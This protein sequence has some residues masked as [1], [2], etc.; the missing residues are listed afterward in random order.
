M[1]TMVVPTHV[2]DRWSSCSRIKK[3]PKPGTPI[4]IDVSKPSIVLYC[5]L[6]SRLLN[7]IAYLNTIIT[8]LFIKYL[9]LTGLQ[10]GLQQC[11]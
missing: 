11:T 9:A 7:N 1:L 2:C 3:A 5:S 6:I 8:T 4:S 10:N